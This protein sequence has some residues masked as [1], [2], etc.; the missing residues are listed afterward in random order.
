MVGGDFFLEWVRE[1]SGGAVVSD[2]GGWGE[3]MVERGQSPAEC[4]TYVAPTGLGWFFGL[5]LGRCPRL[6]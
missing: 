3:P 4:L 1:E 5:F 2:S 6:S